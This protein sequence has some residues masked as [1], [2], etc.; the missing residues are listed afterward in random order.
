MA[1]RFIGTMSAMHMQTSKKYHQCKTRKWLFKSP[2]GYPARGKIKSIY[3][4]EKQAPKIRCISNCV[5]PCNRGEEARKV[6]YCIADRL[7]SAYFGNEEDGLFLLVQTDI[8]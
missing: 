8:D 7:S 5:Q 3:S 1:T 4:G 6:G 2:V